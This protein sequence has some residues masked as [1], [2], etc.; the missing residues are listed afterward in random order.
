VVP[1][2]LHR[3]KFAGQVV[4]FGMVGALNTGV[5]WGLFLV[6]NLVFN[7]LSAT[8]LVEH[9]VLYGTANTI[10]YSAGIINSFLWNKHW[11]FSAG[12]TNRWKR[13]ALLFLAVSVFSLAVNNGGLFLLRSVFS[14]TSLVHVGVHKLGTTIVTMTLNFFGYRFL[15]FSH[16]F[17]RS[18]HKGGA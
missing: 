7:A 10:A 18:P 5:D 15:A 9:P 3:D 16:A 17:P 4:R 11:T 6:F 2:F 12:G 1:G 13:E 14:G 8:N